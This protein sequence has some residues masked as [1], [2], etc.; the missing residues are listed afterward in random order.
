MPLDPLPGPDE[1]ILLVHC[2]GSQH[3]PMS[4]RELKTKVDTG[5]VGVQDHF[6]WNG[7]DGWEVIG[8]HPE[9]FEGLATPDVPAPTPG[10]SEDDRLDAVFGD[11][12]EQSWRHFRAHAFAS[13]VDEVFLGAVITSTLDRGYALIDITSDGTHHYLRFEDMEDH[14]RVIYRLTHLTADLTQSK[15]QGHQ[16]KVI[17]G[18][19]E[20]MKNFTKV[21]KA[22]QA[23]WK[24]GYLRS[25]E[26]GT[27]TVDGDMQSS[28]I[29]VQIDMFWKLDDY[30]GE[31]YAIDYDELGDHV[32]ATVHALRKYLRG[33]FA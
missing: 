22:L 20:R 4:R 17:V 23:E 16:A 26:P 3:G 13:H 14:S 32:H 2:D 8:E 30:I 31:D 15:V 9:L 29:Y 27:I 18:Y 11:L 7:L 12:I 28:Y 5:D 6:W 33:R 25:A 19:G 21:W 1:D 24:S 10:K